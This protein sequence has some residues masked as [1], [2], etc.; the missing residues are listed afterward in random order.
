MRTHTVDE[1]STTLQYV[2]AL[3]SVYLEKFGVRFVYPTDEWY[4]VAD[5]TVPPLAHYDDQALH[6]N[7][8][9]MV[10]YFLDEWADVKV[11]ISDWLTGR[12]AE[13]FQFTKLSLITATLFSEMLSRCTR[14][15]I[16]LVA[17]GVEVEVIPLTNLRL[18]DKITV[19]GLLMGEDVIAQLSELE[20]ERLG[21]VIILPRVMFDHPDT[22]SLDDLSPQDVANRLARPVALADT[23]GDVWDVM[24]GDSKTLVYPANGDALHNGATLIK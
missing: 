23:M 14:E 2:E 22:I 12:S 4:L 8:L 24:I 13:R 10:R 16:G 1:A 18:G 9:G 17:L 20:P 5:Q 7:G 3:Q 15:L 21:E 11:E 6:E 19:A